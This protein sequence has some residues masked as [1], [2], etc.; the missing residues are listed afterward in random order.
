M[1]AVENYLGVDYGEARLG[2]AL[3][4]SIARLPST[5]AVLPND[6]EIVNTLQ[7]I[8]LSERIDKLVIGLPRNMSGEETEQSKTIRQFVENLSRKVA[9]PIVFADES[10]S[11]IRAAEAHNYRS[12]SDR[13]QD[14]IA[15][16]YILE[17][18]LKEK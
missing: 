8:T 18:F 17:E 6:P 5:Y 3:A 7:E 4:N 15:A 13:Y 10:L 2:L 1:N 12:T 16:C 14:D 11:S 9:K